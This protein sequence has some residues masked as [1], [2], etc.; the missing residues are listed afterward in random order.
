MEGMTC[1]SCSA[2]VESAVA[3]L[4]GV[5]HAAVSLLQ[6]EARVEYEEGTTD[7]VRWQGSADQVN[8]C[9]DGPRCG[10]AMP[11]RA[12]ALQLSEVIS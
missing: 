6:G 8:S 9:A 3:G 4:P 2:A 12:R 10:C 11:D 7:E 1:S 5:R